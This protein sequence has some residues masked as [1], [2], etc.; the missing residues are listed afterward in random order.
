[1]YEEENYNEALEKLRE[2]LDNKNKN[3]ELLEMFETE[4]SVIDTYNKI[5]CHPK[6]QQLQENDFKGFLLK[7][8]NHHWTRLN[9]GENE[10]VSD[11]KKL[12]D[13]LYTLV[14]ESQPIVDRINNARKINYLGLGKL[15]PI[16]MMANEEKYGVCNDLVRQFFKD[17]N[18]LPQNR[19]ESGE[20][21][22]E[23]NKILNK[24]SKDLN[25]SLW[26]VD[27][28]FFAY[29]KIPEN[30]ISVYALTLSSKEGL[31][32][33]NKTLLHRV[34]KGEISNYTTLDDVY[35]E[36]GKINLWGLKQ[37][38]NSNGDSKRKDRNYNTFNSF[39]PNDLFIFI[40]DN[41]NI[42]VA[43]ILKKEKN[44]ELAKKI[45]GE[46]KDGK[47]WGLIFFVRVLGIS[48]YNKE[49]FLEKLGYDKIQ[50]TI[51]ITS[52]FYAHYPS[53]EDFLED[54]KDNSITPEILGERLDEEEIE[55]ETKGDINKL[56]E[57]LEEALKDKS[58]KYVEYNGKQY[59]RKPIFVKFVKK[60]DEEECQACGCKI[61]KKKKG[62][63]VEVAHIKALSEGGPDD[64][65]NMVALCPNCHKKLDVGREDLREEVLKNLK[66]KL[67]RKD[68]TDVTQKYGY[69]I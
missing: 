7:K 18:L 23:V 8:N 13:T 26:K 64:P 63:Y 3:P 69:I 52:K 59:R 51:N 55:E 30:P 12:S 47:T 46:D 28:L 6:D 58:T 54:Y 25:I 19:M 62:Y 60:R 9:G 14:D 5:F 35:Y 53:M 50:G 49:T 57:L 17:Y 4:R 67:E 44:E 66:S 29:S 34:D 33:M 40:P 27:A 48:Q 24:F 2:I 31:Y 22:L 65:R 61:K 39:K 56:L 41:G 37:G 68:K 36:N 20:E 32:N 45:W 38:D 15:T 42:I 11:M 43:S 21:Y 1:M 16:L 10:I